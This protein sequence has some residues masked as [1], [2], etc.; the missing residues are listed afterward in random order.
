MRHWSGGQTSDREE[1]SSLVFQ[2]SIETF[3]GL[4]LFL[5]IGVLDHIKV[6]LRLNA[7]FHLRLPHRQGVTR[8]LFLELRGVLLCLVAAEVKLENLPAM[9]AVLLVAEGAIEL[10]SFLALNLEGLLDAGGRHLRQDGP[11]PVFA[12]SIFEGLVEKD[13]RRSDTIQEVTSSMGIVVVVPLLVGLSAHVAD[14]EKYF[15]QH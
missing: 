4:I 11:K 10:E 8:I 7:R 6:V 9:S 12:L 1:V 5:E 2:R 13:R 15:T 14:G 3:T